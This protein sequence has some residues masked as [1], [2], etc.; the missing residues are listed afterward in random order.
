VKAGFRSARR[1]RMREGR[2]QGARRETHHRPFIK[3][4]LDN[5][6]EVSVLLVTEDDKFAD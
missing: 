6:K 4:A 1:R 3:R 5:V 2:R